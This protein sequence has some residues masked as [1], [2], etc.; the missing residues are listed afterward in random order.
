MRVPIATKLVLGFLLVIFLT[1]LIFSL[2]GVRI[3]SDR[4]VAEAQE[5][6]RTDLNSAREIYLSKL[7]HINDAV[8]FT[9]DRAL[10]MNA[11]LS[12]QIKQA[13]EALGKIK[14]REGLDVLTIADK[15]GKVLLRTSNL[16]LAGDDQSHDEL[17]HFVI[18][19]KAP[20]AATVIV[21]PE[22]LWRESP[23]LA[24]RAYFR[25]IPTPK[26]RPRRDAEAASGMMLKAAA[27]I[28]D[29]DN[30]FIGVAYGGVLLNRNFEIVDKVKQT[31]FQDVKYKGEDIGTATIFLDDLR[32]STNV[33]NEDGSRAIGT[34]IA[35]DVYNQVV[36][37]GKQ[38]IGRAYVVNKWYITAYEPI[39]NLDAS[40]I[41][42]LYVGLL[43]QKYLDIKHRTV[44]VFLAISF[45]GALVALALSYFV[46]RNLSSSVNK[47]ASASH[48]VAHGNLDAKVEIK[49]NDELHELA[50]TFNLMASALKR[51]D[52]QLKEFT[53]KKIMESERLALIGQLAAG[54]AHELNNPLQG[55]VMYSHLLLEKMPAQNGARESVQKI[56]TQATRS[57]DIIRGL[58]DFSRQRKPDKRP[59]NVN[60]LLQECLSLVGNQALFHNIELVKRLRED[61]PLVPMDPSQIQQVFMN[62]IINAAEAMNGGGRLTL[63]TRFDPAA[64]LV[65]VAFADTGHGIREEDLE[66]I[67][68]PIFTTKEA[69]HGTGLGLAIS[70]GIV[71]EHR[72]TISVESEVGKGTTFTVRLP[73][74]AEERA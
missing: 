32:I 57:R 47:L 21:P 50:D 8:R 74:S 69:G 61:L 6:V 45:L 12:G 34:R 55:I 39:R 43:E 66:R 13:S 40:I 72:G 17:V 35:E 7:S 11:L 2:V 60:V 59:S 56:A 70:Y 36:K 4:V 51:R 71:K 25:F 26:A 54:V 73:V 52:E 20:V 23:V 27:P 46:S 41:G 37:A 63:A 14:E 18:E 9:A 30:N 67:F 1:S 22:D 68:D 5:K 48:E 10:L 58:L 19:R 44:R 24:E 16:S 15:T 42:I 49:S 29:L 64:T 38:W 65:E 28:F 3:I 53:T 62:M 33:K 31:V